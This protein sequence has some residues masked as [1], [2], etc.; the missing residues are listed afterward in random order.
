[1]SLTVASAALDLA[2]VEFGVTSI[3][4]GTLDAV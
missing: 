2:W 3:T 1:M 4:A